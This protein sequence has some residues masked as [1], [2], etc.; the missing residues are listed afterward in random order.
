MNNKKNQSIEPTLYLGIRKKKFLIK[1]V[2]ACSSYIS[3]RN[4]SNYYSAFYNVKDKQYVKLGR[5][6]SA[7]FNIHDLK[8]TTIHTHLPH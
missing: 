2:L 5:S 7:Q 3:A 4:R 8:I 1:N 6:F